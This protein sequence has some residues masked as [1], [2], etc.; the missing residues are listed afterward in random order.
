M[1]IQIANTQFEWELSQ[2]KKVSIIE[3][4]ESHSVFMQ[5][6]FL[7]L[8]YAREDDIVA[9]TALPTEEWMQLGKRPRLCL[10]KDPS[11]SEKV[12]DW[13]A[14]LAIQAWASTHHLSYSMP[15]IECV[16]TV[17][18]KA[19]SFALGNPLPGSAL[20]Y[21]QEDVE[22]WLAK[23]KD[24]KVLKTCFGVSGKGHLVIDH[25]YPVSSEKIDRFLMPEWQAKRPVLAEPW[26]KR[27]LDFSTQWLIAPDST[28]SC[29]GAT[30]CKNDAQ[31]RHLGNV[32]GNETQLFG[33]FFH[34]LETHKQKAELALKTMAEQGYFGHVG[35]DA[36]VYEYENTIHLQ[37]VVEINARKTM[38]WVALDVQKRH[39]PTQ[40]I[41]LSYL[42][43]DKPGYLPSKLM[44]TT[45]QVTTFSR[46]LNI[47][48][49]VP[50]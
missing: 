20:L 31:G 18:S 4:I 26:V 35:F 40:N 1:K 43:S 23:T 5:L 24:P 28:I 10:L 32:V 48:P 17:N 7:P 11:P 50:T 37:P 13:G 2:E 49:Y 34:F 41:L 6:Q 22:Q 25:R 16:R 21:N 46:Q 36:M 44:R 15:P 39:F 47:Q 33:S 14:S 29:V 30:L 38:G 42:P 45:G 3:G 9:V 19:F 8:L 12:E 27:H